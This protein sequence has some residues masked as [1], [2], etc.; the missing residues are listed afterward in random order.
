MIIAWFI[1]HVE[2]LFLLMH[3]EGVDYALDIAF[4]HWASFGAMVVFYSVLIFLRKEIRSYF[5]TP[6]AT[7]IE[8]VQS[9][10]FKIYSNDFSGSSDEATAEKVRSLSET[11]Y[12]ILRSKKVTFG[13]LG[14]YFGIVFPSMFFK[15]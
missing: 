11:A 12:R 15:F 7:D 1:F 13:G 5:V 14:L 3:L 2:K 8:I 10:L 4:I 9:K 6:D